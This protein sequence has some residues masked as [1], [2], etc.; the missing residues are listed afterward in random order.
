M[1]D[2]GWNLSATADKGGRLEGGEGSEG[3]L[4]SR[5]QKGGGR[6]GGGGGEVKSGCGRALKRLPWSSNSCSHTRNLR[7]SFHKHNGW[8]KNREAT[9]HQK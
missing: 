7:R 5:R 3:L 1:L 2:L 8:Q 9:L 6:R 4:L